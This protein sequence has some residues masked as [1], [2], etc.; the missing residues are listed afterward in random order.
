[1][2]GNDKAVAQPTEHVHKSERGRTYEPG[3]NNR[4]V[5]HAKRIK[6]FYLPES[7]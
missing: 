6:L 2:L 3:S 4:I 7:V 5:A 1:M